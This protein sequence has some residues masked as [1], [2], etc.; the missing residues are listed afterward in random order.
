MTRS[1][2]AFIKYP[3]THSQP[4]PSLRS[5]RGRGRKSKRERGGEIEREREDRYAFCVTQTDGQT[6]SIWADEEQWSK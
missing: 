5:E 1:I 6:D 3:L 2:K 4:K